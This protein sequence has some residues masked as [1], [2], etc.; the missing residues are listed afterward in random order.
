[1]VKSF[2]KFIKENLE[3]GWDNIETIYPNQRGD[4]QLLGD[5]LFIEKKHLLRDG[6]CDSQLTQ[7]VKELLVIGY[8]LPIFFDTDDGKSGAIMGTEEDMFWT[9]MKK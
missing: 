9:I 1:M 8:E 7:K 6:F 4:L 2:Y 5:S 3:P